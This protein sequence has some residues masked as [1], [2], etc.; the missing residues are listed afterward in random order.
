MRVEFGHAHAHTRYLPV[1]LLDYLYLLVDVVIVKFYKY[2]SLNVH[3]PFEVQHPTVYSTTIF[4]RGYIKF[5]EFLKNISHINLFWENAPEEIY[6]TWTLKHN[7]TDWSQVPPEVDL[8][9]DIGHLSLGAVNISEARKGIRR[10]I[11]ERG[12]QIKHLHLHTNN[13]KADQHCTDI[14][15]IERVFSKK[16]I[17]SLKVGRTYIYEQGE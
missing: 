11:N 14:V 15:L 10:L 16:L 3:L 12:H 2:K 4:S 7:Q 9:L 1:S 8:C 17:D 5:G 6:G 13:L